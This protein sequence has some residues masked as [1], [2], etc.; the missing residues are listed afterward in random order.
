MSKANLIELPLV[1][2]GHV[3]AVSARNGRPLPKATRF[4]TVTRAISARAACV[5]NA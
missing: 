5:R 3:N 2:L 1:L 4:A